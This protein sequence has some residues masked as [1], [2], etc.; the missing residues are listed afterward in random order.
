MWAT[1]VASVDELLGG[2]L[3]VGSLTEMVGPE[4]SGRTSLALSYVAACTRAGRIC[5][6]IDVSDTLS[7][8]SAAA[9]GVRLDQ[10]L[11][12]RC[13]VC[14]QAEPA[15]QQTFQLP[16]ECFTPAAPIKGLYAGGWGGHPRTEVNGIAGAVSDLLAPSAIE[17]RCAEPQKRVKLP[18]EEPPHI[19]I[20]AT[21]KPAHKPQ[22]QKPWA[23]MEQAMRA[24]DLL[25]Q[26]GGFAVVVL[27]MAGLPAEAALR[28]P[29]ATWFR[30]RAAAE[31]TQASVVLLTQRACAK[32]SAGLVLKMEQAAEISECS[33][34]FTG[35]SCRMEVLRER[36]QPTTNV[37]LLRKPPMR[38]SVADWQ[39][40]STW[41]G[42]R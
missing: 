8:E 29:L 11:W 24:T 4:C 32:S 41:A 31:R 35:L 12:V 33:T 26:T 18:R 5:A 23:R 30:Y 14:K 7:P 20:P 6:W 39:A 19:S 13:G 22:P 27:D 25:L 1:G 15:Q 38:A 10:L 21:N 9:A 17:P 3:P 2:G 36:F 42:V 40:R 37:V 16:T 28:V 34:V